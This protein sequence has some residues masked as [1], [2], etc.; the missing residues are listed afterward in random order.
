MLKYTGENYGSDGLNHWRE[1]QGNSF[2]PNVYDPMYVNLVLESASEEMRWAKS[3]K[4]WKTIPL[5]TMNEINLL[6]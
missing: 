2:V 5:G 4:S 1:G 6:L 3:I